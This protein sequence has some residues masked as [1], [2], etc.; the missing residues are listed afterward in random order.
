MVGMPEA[1]IILSQAVTYLAASP[2]SN[3]AYLAIDEALAD[4]KKTGMLEI[5]LNLRNAPTKLM[6]DMGY[7]Q[8][9][10]Y[11]HDDPKGASLQQ[12]LPDQLK[13]KTYYRPLRVGAEA[14]LLKNLET[15]SG[16]SDQGA[17]PR[18]A[19]D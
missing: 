5:P 4:V 7:G 18:P 1:R 12:Y 15:I 10:I 19:T 16:V 14:Q 11:A 17:R 2:K 8:A 6:K 3:R 9:Y 13:H